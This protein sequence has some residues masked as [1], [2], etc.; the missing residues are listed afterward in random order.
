M[1]TQVFLQVEPLSTLIT[2]VNDEDR[3]VRRMQNQPALGAV[4]EYGGNCKNQKRRALNS[5]VECHLHTVE[6]IGSN[7]IAPTN[8]LK[9][10][11]VAGRSP[12]ATSPSFWPAT[13]D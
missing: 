7:P 2:I 8:P 9:S 12:L 13:K 5:A 10:K 1:P 4:D 3:I 6:V 11:Q